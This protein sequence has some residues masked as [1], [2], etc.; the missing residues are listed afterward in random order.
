MKTIKKHPTIK[1]KGNDLLLPLLERKLK[2]YLE[3]YNTDPTATRQ[4]HIKTLLFFS[5][6]C[7]IYFAIIFGYLPISRNVLWILLGL[8]FA[9][10]GFNIMHDA[11]HNSYSKN[12]IINDLLVL[13]LNLVGGS[14]Y[15]WRV[16]HNILHHTYTN[17]DGHDEDV[18][19]GP[20]RLH[21]NQPLKKWHRYQHIYGLLFYTAT[22]AWWIWYLDYAKY[23]SGKINGHTFP[24][25][26]F[27]NHVIFWVSKIFYVGYIVVIPWYFL[28]F[29][30]FL[31]G[32]SLLLIVCGFFI[33]IIFQLAH[34]V[35]DVDNPLIDEDNEIKEEWCVHQIRTTANFA[36]KNKI[37]SFFIGGLNFQIEHHLFPK[38]NHVH[39]AKLQP[40]IKDACIEKNVKY[41]END[42]FFSAFA[43]HLRRLKKLGTEA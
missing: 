5:S 1:K 17:V 10:I 33:S 19:A 37:L 14:S 32:Y 34:I 43:S 38:V 16:K 35:E 29:W 30:Q 42:T 13:S 20:M 41:I 9:C 21:R 2:Y 3:K 15:L 22:Y 23:F 25:M 40:Y 36:T 39:Y 11:G 24:K 27:K 4:S 8:N 6:A 31:L 28:G 12:K 7:F 26:K 18:A